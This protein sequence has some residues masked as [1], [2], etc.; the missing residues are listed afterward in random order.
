MLARSGGRTHLCSSLLLPNIF[1]PNT[2]IWRTKIMGKNK[3]KGNSSKGKNEQAV[4]GC[5]EA[6]KHDGPISSDK[7]GNVVIKILAKP[8]AKENGFTD[9]STEGVGVQIA[10]PPTEGEANTEL[11]KFL[12]SALGVRKSDVSLDR[13]SRSRQKTVKVSG[14]SVADVEQKLK[15]CCK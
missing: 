6:V 1:H 10:A 5:S 8:G 7:S 4:S 3:A 14:T 11:V 15:N 12:A 2:T 9:I 13:G